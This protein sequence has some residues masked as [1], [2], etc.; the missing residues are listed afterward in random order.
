MN[1]C[2]NW[3]DRLL[4]HT[5]GA[6]PPSAVKEVEA[7]LEKCSACAA[8]M[9]ELRH[10][11]RQLDS[12]LAGWVAG[13]EPPPDFRPRVLSVVETRR[14]LSLTPPAWAGALAAVV[15]VFLGGALLQRMGD[16]GAGST[17]GPTPSLSTW[18]SPTETL[19]HS[20]DG[21][22]LRSAPRLGESYYPLAPAPAAAGS[23]HGG[24]NE[25]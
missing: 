22:F 15:V 1:P 13:A 7:H 10:R 18:R 21:E 19:L 9:V 23:K 17:L 6:L 8:A 16:A 11:G 5:L 25:S 3:K 24:N 12:V 2:R 4:D 14:G 20:P